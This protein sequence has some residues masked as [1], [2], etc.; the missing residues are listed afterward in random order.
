MFVY[1]MCI[2]I[3]IYIYVYERENMIYDYN[4]GSV[5][6]DYMEAGEEKR[7]TENK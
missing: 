6:G 4:H 3:Y 5:S 2:Y 1:F 7:M